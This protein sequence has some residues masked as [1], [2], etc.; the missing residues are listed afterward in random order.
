MSTAVC[1]ASHALALS[2][3]GT[4][5]S[6]PPQ[7]R[8]RGRRWIVLGNRKVDTWDCGWCHVFLRGVSLGGC[9]VR[10]ACRTLC[11]DGVR[12][13]SG[14]AF[15]LAGGRRLLCG[16]HGCR[17]VACSGKRRRRDHADRQHDGEHGGNGNGRGFSHSCACASRKYQARKVQT[18]DHF[19]L[20]SIEDRREV[21]GG[22]V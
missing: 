4:G 21:V 9:A 13:G 19:T 14:I 10:A 1:S 15:G 12:V 11:G 5:Q 18:S 3:T 8:R 17:R 6:F 22:E 16:L 20:A 2:A 7:G